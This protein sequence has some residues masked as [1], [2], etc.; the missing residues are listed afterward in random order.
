MTDQPKQ[1]AIVSQRA[2]EAAAA[3]RSWLPPLAGSR[4]ISA[5]R[6]GGLDDGAYI[7]AFARF[8]AEIAAA[9]IERCAG[10]AHLRDFECEAN[11]RKGGQSVAKYHNECRA[12]EARHIKAEIL[13]L[14]GQTS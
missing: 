10:V 8:Q 6:D 7:Q 1:D 13:N 4:E 5:M 11:A 2:M 12:M 14:K 9:T 3:L